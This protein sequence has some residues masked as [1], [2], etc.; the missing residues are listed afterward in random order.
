M[1]IVALFMSKPQKQYTDQKKPTQ[2]NHM[3][4]KSIYMRKGKSREDKPIET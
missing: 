1:F 4:Y 2:K 3:L